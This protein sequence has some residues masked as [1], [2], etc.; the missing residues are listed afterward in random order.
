M[1]FTIQNQTTLDPSALSDELVTAFG[2]NYGIS[3]AGT[4]ITTNSAIEPDA[5]LFQAVLD[6]HV[7]DAPR[8]AQLRHRKS[9]GDAIQNLL[10]T[11]ASPDY[12]NIHTAIG[13]SNDYPKAMQ[14]RVWAKACWDK[15]TQIE[16]A[17]LAGTRPM[18]T[19]AEALAEMPVFIR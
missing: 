19:T 2:T 18:P 11:T 1:K 16:L 9:I 5:V 17:V 15:A 7:A 13:W 6:A 3:T 14:L 12:D 10:D 8:R 4:E